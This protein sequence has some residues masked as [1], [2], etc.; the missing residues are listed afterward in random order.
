MRSYFSATGYGLWVCD[1]SYLFVYGL[2]GISLFLR[3]LQGL[4]VIQNLKVP[5]ESIKICILESRRL[6]NC[7]RVSLFIY[8]RKIKMLLLS[9]SNLPKPIRVNPGQ[10]IAGHVFKTGET[11]LGFWRLGLDAHDILAPEIEWCLPMRRLIP[12]GAYLFATSY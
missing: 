5:S 1:V 11:V 3:G 7:D 4:P 8:D 9:A 2:P 10:G 12:R 6:L